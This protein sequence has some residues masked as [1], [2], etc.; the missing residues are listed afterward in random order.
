L[1]LLL[2][3]ICCEGSCNTGD[4]GTEGTLS[5]LFV[6]HTPV[7]DER[8]QETL[9]QLFVDH[10]PVPDEDDYRFVNS[11]WAPARPLLIIKTN[12][13]YDVAL[14]PHI[15]VEAPLGEHFSIAGEFM[16]GWWQQRDWSRCW[17]LEAVALE[18]RYW[19]RPLMERHRRGGWFA[20]ALV[21][22]GFYD[23]QFNS[24]AG[25]QGE[26][27]MAGVTGGYL[28]P[29]GAH[30]SLE[31][32]LGLGYLHTNY[33]RYNVAP[34]HD[35]HELVATAPPMRLQAFYPLKAGVSLQWTVNRSKKRRAQ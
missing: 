25:V 12:L 1:A 35:G 23:F 21:Q 15:G 18:G 16:R 5:Q 7:P 34:T 27:F 13:L 29:L 22:T 19:F 17:Q 6:D 4:G 28:C 30:W 33:R 14:T 11:L 9:S 32:T 3:Q 10:S 31:F 8:P 24:A 2:Q 26:M 20:G